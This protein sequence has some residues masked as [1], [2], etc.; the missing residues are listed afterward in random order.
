L[1]QQD[2]AKTFA[3]LNFTIIEV[4]QTANRLACDAEERS[5]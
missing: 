2:K 4:L 1:A 5:T 3:A